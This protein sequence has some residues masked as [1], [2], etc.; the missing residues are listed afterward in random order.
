MLPPR[1]QRAEFN[2][3]SLTL[4]TAD[5]AT[6]RDITPIPGANLTV[7]FAALAWACA[8]A[9]EV[10]GGTWPRLLPGFALMIRPFDRIPG[11]RTPCRRNGARILVKASRIPPTPTAPR[12]T[13]DYIKLALKRVQHKQQMCTS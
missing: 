12:P 1:H 8:V 6:A 11:K 13:I 5:L 3:C 4:A 9:W 2:F 7:R 10:V